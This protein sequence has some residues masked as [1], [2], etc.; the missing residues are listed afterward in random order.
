MLAGLIRNRMATTH[1]QCRTCC[2]R[3]NV[4]V[5]RLLSRKRVINENIAEQI[6]VAPL[7]AERAEPYDLK[8]TDYFVE[9]A[10]NELLDP[11][12]PI[13]LGDD[14]AA[15][16]QLVYFG[17]LEVHTTFDPRAQA[18][19]LAARA[20]H[21]PEDERGFTVAIASVDTKTSAVRAMVGGP[22]FQLRRSTSPP[23]VSGSRG[24]R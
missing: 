19:A 5:D 21:L 1:G 4:V 6:R 24:L 9:E 17:G 23:T 2:D 16:Y 14:Q 10:L 15:R 22:D 11:T 13:P 3:R 8:P 18:A 12:S 7:P 20:E